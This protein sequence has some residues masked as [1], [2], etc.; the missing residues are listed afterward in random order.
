MGFL[1]NKVVQILLAVLV[2]IAICIIAGLNFHFQ[3]GSQG[4]SMGVLRGGQ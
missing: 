1:N 4:V 2:V 3:A